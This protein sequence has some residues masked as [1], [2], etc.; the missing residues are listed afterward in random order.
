MPAAYVAQDTGD[1]ELWTRAE[2]LVRSAEECL[3]LSSSLFP[4]Y[5]EQGAAG[6]PCWREPSKRRL[7]ASKVRSC[8]EPVGSGCTISEL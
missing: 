2:E 3:A 4:L 5:V 7:A 1:E 8:A 6:L